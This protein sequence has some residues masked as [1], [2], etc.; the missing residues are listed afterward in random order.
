[1]LEIEKDFQKRT[2]LEDRTRYKLFY[3]HIHAFPAMVL[4]LNPGGSPDGQLFEARDRYYV[5]YEHDYLLFRDQAGYA[6]AGEMTSFLSHVLGTRRVDVLRQV[7]ATNVVFRRS[8]ASEAKGR[9]RSTFASLHGMNLTS[10]FV[11]GRPTLLTI[12]REVNPVLMFVVS[13]QA[14]DMLKTLLSSISETDELSVPNGKNTARLFLKATGVLPILGPEPKS[15]IVTGHPSKYARRREWA[16]V[17]R[18][19]KSECER[20]DVSP[21]ESHPAVVRIPKLSDHGEFI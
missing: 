17:I 2:G 6:L 1:M 3:S 20:L 16:E 14:W 21:I 18:M 7:P 4:G 15:I 9:P 8:P 12:L 5:K 10:A 13:P 11:Q 19:A